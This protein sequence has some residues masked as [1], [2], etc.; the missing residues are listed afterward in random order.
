[1]A[2]LTT[3]IIK[4]LKDIILFCKQGSGIT[5]RNYQIDAALAIFNSIRHHLGHTIVVIFPRQSGKNEL[6]AQIETYL[7]TLYQHLDAEIVKISPTWK[8]QTLN[9]MRRLERVLERNLITRG[10]WCKESG[11]IYRVGSARIFFMSRSPSANVVGATANILLECDEAQDVQIAKWDKDFSPMT[12]S[13]NA[14]K[15]FWGTMWTSRTLLARELRA[16]QAAEARDGIRRVFMMDA[17]DVAKEVPAYWKHVQ[18]Q[19]NK[20]GKNHP[21]VK[22]QYFSQEIDAEGG[23]FTPAR[24]AVMQGKHPPADKADPEK[25]Y[26]VLID[27]AGEEEDKSGE[28]VESEKPRKLGTSSKRDSTAMTIVE[29][30]LASLEDELIKAPTYRVARHYLWTGTNHSDLY[31]QIKSIIDDWNARHIVIDSAGVGAGIASF[32]DHAY[33]NKVIRYHFT[34][35]SKSLLGWGFLA[36]IET[37]RYKEYSISHRDASLK[38]VGSDNKAHLKLQETF[39]QQAETCQMEVLEGSNKM[40]RWGVPDGTRDRESGELIHDDLLISAALCS[41]LDDQEWG[42]AASKVI[43]GEAIFDEMADAF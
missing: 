26:C 3:I 28:L 15:V 17:H 31:S 36:V 19:I 5:L 1:M 24:L 20:L 40:M 29:V 21:F 18:E 25:I 30:D 42:I 16:A 38:N 9:A 12:A 14:T 39:W 7:L 27:V 37:G 35:K 32:L 4:I 6:Q 2:E 22:T 41:V 8:P 10:S 23:M 13:T 34:S 11:Y 43:D 33:P